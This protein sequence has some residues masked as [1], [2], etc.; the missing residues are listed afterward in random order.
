MNHCCDCNSDYA[1]PGTCN[2]FAVGGKRYAGGINEKPF[3]SIPYVPY[4]P[5]PWYPT[6]PPFTITGGSVAADST[7]TITFNCE[8]KIA[9]NTVSIE[10][11]GASWNSLRDWKLS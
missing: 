1:T 8:P 2:C 10:H 6:Y 9:S 5:Y 7:A 11:C 3:P 4:T